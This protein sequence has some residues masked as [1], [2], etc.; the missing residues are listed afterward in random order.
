MC[1]GIAA[2]IAGMSAYGYGKTSDESIAAQR[3][4]TR[5][6]FADEFDVDGSVDTTRW[7]YEQGYLRNGELQYYTCG[8]NTCC[9][10][11]CLIIECRNDSAEIDG[12]V[13]PVTSASVTTKGHR[14]WTY[15]Y[16]EVRA[17]LPSALG[18]WPAIWMMPAQDVY[19]KWPRSGEIDI[20]E[21]VGY[22]PGKIHFSAHT[23]RLNHRRGTQ[24]TH[25]IDAPEAVGQ[26][27]VYGLEW[28][29]DRLVWL[30]DGN[31]VYT[32]EREENSDWTSWP[33]N[34][35]Y[36]LILNFAFGGG[37]GGCE[38]VDLAALPQQ[39]EIDYVRLYQ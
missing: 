38:G 37:W 14:E 15:G 7:S 25:Q 11:G 30:Y 39:F 13:C 17:K 6:V 24:R 3:G 22:N 29:A 12:Q 23:E 32:I 16:V 20:L 27:H 8:A 35:D 2:A 9:K 28:T 1:L 33:F 5:L 19:G 34:I 31:E 10:D 18:T 21:H 36:Y 26:F 4:Y